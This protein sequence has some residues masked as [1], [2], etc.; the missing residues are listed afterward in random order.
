MLTGELRRA[1]LILVNVDDIDMGYDRNPDHQNWKVWT[2][3]GEMNVGVMFNESIDPI[4]CK[5]YIYTTECNLWGLRIEQESEPLWDYHI[6]DAS[7][8]V[9][10]YTPVEFCYRCAAPICKDYTKLTQL[11]DLTNVIH[12][13]INGV[14]WRNNVSVGVRDDMFKDIAVDTCSRP[15]IRY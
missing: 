5:T 14:R 9:K 13:Y 15:I 4:D 11:E 7:F 3:P 12:K 6:Q 8:R 2:I 1:G 10:I